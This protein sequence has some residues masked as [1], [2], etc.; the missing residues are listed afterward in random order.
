[1]LLS[2]K[3][4]ARIPMEEKEDWKFHN[5]QLLLEHYRDVIWSLELAVHQVNRNIF[6]E[7]G[8][9]IEGFLDMTY[10]AGMEFSGTEIE[11]HAKT[12]ARSRNMI[13]IIN[14]AVKLLREKHKFGEI[15]YWIL[16]YSYLSPQEYDNIDEIIEK[17]SGYLKDISKRTYYRKR[18]EA[19]RQLGRLLWGYTSRDCLRIIEVF[20]P[21]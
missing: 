9:D 17:L 7:F 14:S 18:N 2:F 3:R 1:M 6:L 4:G 12:I 10:E 16:Y 13:Q 21:E 19:I 5:T 11:A 20:I 8:S 15:Y